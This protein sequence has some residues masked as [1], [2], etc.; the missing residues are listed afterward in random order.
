[1]REFTEDRHVFQSVF[2]FEWVENI[3]G[4]EKMMV[5]NIFSFSHAF[6]NPLLQVRIVW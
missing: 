4:K 5:T 3:V 1:M 6:K 2:V